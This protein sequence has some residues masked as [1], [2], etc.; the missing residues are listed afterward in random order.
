MARRK[1]LYRRERH[2]IRR[3]TRLSVLGIGGM[4]L[5]SLG[6]P[7][8]AAPRISTTALPS[9][10]VGQPLAPGSTTQRIPQ[11]VAGTFANPYVVNGN[12]GTITQDSPA[13]ILQWGSFD[14]GSSSKVVINLPSENAVLLNKVSGGEYLNKTVIEGMLT[15]NGKGQ[16]YIYN[17]NGIIF[18]KNSVVDLNTFVATTLKVDDS[19]FLGGLLVPS[20]SP[21]FEAE[22]AAPGGITVEGVSALERARITAARGG[23]ILLVAPTIENNGV[24]SAPDGQ[25]ALAAGGRVYL[26]SPSDKNMRG[27]LIEV[28]SRNLTSKTSSVTNQSLGQVLV[29]RGNA[30]L[31]GYA[32]N[33]NGLVSATT[34]VALNGSIYLHARDQASKSNTTDPAKAVRGGTLILGEGS[35]TEI[36]PTLG[37]GIWTHDNKLIPTK[38][39]SSSFMRS[40]ADLSGNTV[41]LMQGA[42]LVVPGGDV[43]VS[44]RVDP[45]AAAPS[46]SS[47]SRI[48]LEEGARIDVS[49]STSALDMEDNVIEV[50]LRGTEL[51]DVP[52]QRYAVYRGA[53]VYVDVRKGTTLGNIQGW[54]DGVQHS[55]GEFT[56]NGGKVLFRSDGDV[57]LA[58]G[59]MVNVSG[60]GINYRD[61]YINT[62]KLI[63][64]NR[65]YDIGSASPDLV[66]DKFYTNSTPTQR[67][68]QK[69]Y[70]QG[71]N[72]GSITVDASAAVLRGDLKGSA[73]AGVLQRDAGASSRPKGGEL[74]IG[75]KIDISGYLGF[76]FRS[77]VNLGGTSTSAI[78][79]PAFGDAWTNANSGLKSTL[80]LDMDQLGGNGFSRVGVYTL[81]DIVVSKPATLSAGGELT[82]YAMNGVQVNANITAPGGALKA[83]SALDKV[84]VASGVT[85][86]TAG[87]WTNDRNGAATDGNGNPTDTIVTG[88][89]NIDL[90][91]LTVEIGD[92]VTLDVSG[93]AWLSSAGKTTAGKGGSIN[94]KAN[95]VDK[96]QSLDLDL[97]GVLSLGRNLTLSGYGVGTGG[98]VSLAGRNV[99]IG[100]AAAHANDLSLD[101][102]WF[103]RGGFSSY[104][105][106][107]A[108]NLTVAAG[109]TLTPRM[110]NWIARSNTASQ[111]SGLMRNA[112]SIGTLPLAGASGSRGAASVSLTAASAAADGY[113][114]LWLK[115]GASIVTDPGGSVTLSAGRQLT[116]DGTVRTPGGAINLY[117]TP[118]V[119]EVDYR[120]ERAVWLGAHSLLDASGTAARLW[121][122]GYGL[123]QGDVLGGG[124][125]KIGR[126]DKVTGTFSALTGYVVAESG[127]RLN[128]SGT[129]APMHLNGGRGRVDV[130]RVAS[131]GGTIDIRAQEG[132]LFEGSFSAAGGNY[133]T[134][135]G[136]LNLSVDR[137]SIATY[138][139]Y[140]TAPRT[141]VLARVKPNAGSP[142]EGI[143]PHGLAA[144]QAIT[145]YDGVGYI[146]AD[147]IN[148]GG[149]DR[150]R[151]KAQDVVSFD[152]HGGSLSLT[153]RTSLVVDAPVTSLANGAAGSTV[154]LNSA[155]VQLGNADW[156]Y[157]AAGAAATATGGNGALAVNATTID[158]V[159]RSVL[160]GF[161]LT[162]FVAREDIRLVGQLDVDTTAV[163]P[164]VLTPLHAI[165]TFSA[166]GAT[167][168]TAGQIYPTSMSEFT[169]HGVGSGNS[170]TFNSNGQ[171]AASPLSAAGTLTVKAEDIYQRGVLRA[172][173]GRLD[174][175][176]DNNL[177]YAPGSLTS[178]AGNGTVPLGRI[179]NGRQWLY[180][181]GNGYT[182][183]LNDSA[184]TNAVSLPEKAVVSKGRNVTF[185]SGAT[186]DLSGGGK[187][188][189]YEFTAGPGGSKD[190][191]AASG[192]TNGIY[193][194]LPG[195]TA[196]VA[197]RDFQYGQ[198]SALQSGE[199]IYLS[200][201]P[202]LAAGYYTLLP[203]H[204]ALLPGAYAVTLASGTR[205]MTA[206][207]TYLKTDGTW[208]V[209][210]YRASVGSS[211]SRSNGYQVYS[212]SQA[213]TYSEFSDYSASSFF[214]GTNWTQPVDGGHAA[215]AVTDSLT[216]KGL[217]NLQAGTGGK[218]GIA[219]I[220]AP[221]IEVVAEES[222]STGSALKLLAADLTALNADSLLLGGLR[223]IKSDGIHLTVGAQTVTASNNAAHPLSGSEIML[224]ATDT[225][226]AK[227]NSVVSSSGVYTGTRGDLIVEGTG[228]GA[229]G[230]L[231]RVS[232]GAQRSLVRTTPAGNTGTL[233]IQAGA[234]VSASA[235]MALDA[236]KQLNF[237]GNL[238]LGPGAAL[239]LGASRISLG[240]SAPSGLPGLQFSGARLAALNSLASLGLT[241]YST[242][243]IYG[244]VTLGRDG[245]T[246]LTVRA[247]G[248]QSYNNTSADTTRLLADTVRFEGGGSFSLATPAPASAQGTLNVAAKS[249][250]VGSGTFEVRGN[251]GVNLNALSEIRMDGKSGMLSVQGD[252]NATAGR[253]AASSG[254]DGVIKASGNLVL[255]KTATPTAPSTTSILGGRIGFVG[256]TILSDGDISAHS[257][258]ITMTASN[259]V[260]IASGSLDAA[261]EAI[262]YGSKTAYSGGGKVVLDGGTGSV[263]VDA[264]TTIDVSSTRADAGTLSVTSS[265][266][267]SG[268]VTLAGT[269][270]GA[271]GADADGVT[272]AQG[273]FISDT[274]V[275]SGF[276]A[277]NQKL[278]NSGFGGTRQFSVRHGDVALAVG[279]TITAK[280]VLISLDNGNLTVGGTIDARG[281]KGGTIQLY[282]AQATATGNSGN[283]TLQNTARLLA[284][285]T[286]AASSAA[287]SSGDG[288]KVTLGSANAAG[289]T[290]AGTSGNSSLSVLSGAVIDVSG[291]GSGQAG[292]VLLRAPR[293]GSGAGT[294]LAISALA[295]TI[296]GSGETVLEGYKVYTGTQITAAAGTSSNLDARTTGTMY[297]E[298]STF[299]GNSG[300]ILSRLGATSSG[301]LLRTGI[302][303][304]STGDLLVNVNETATN[305]KD[306]GWDLNQWRFGG[307]PGMLTLRAASNL[308][309][310]GSISDGFVKPTTTT[311]MPDWSLDPTGGA[312]WSYR[313]VGGARTASANPLAVN[314]STSAGDVKVTF[315][316]T[317]TSG[318]D[319]SVAL[320][321]TGS[322]SID[323][324]AGRDIVL[325]SVGTGTGLIGATI[326]TAGRHVSTQ[327]VDRTLPDYSASDSTTATPKNQTANTAY[328][329]GT[330]TL[331]AEFAQG[332][333]SIGL[334]A[335]RNITGPATYQVVNNWLFRRGKTTTDANGNL[336][337][338]TSSTGATSTR[339]TLSTAWWSR[340][341]YFNQ[342]VATLAGGDV[343]VI[344]GGNITDLALSTATNGQV[345]GAAPG[346]APLTE[347][348]GGNLSLSA[349][350][351]IYGGSF[352]VQKGEGNITAAGS[353]LGGTRTVNGALLRPILA[354]GDASINV[355]AGS[356]LEIETV[357]NPTMTRQSTANAALVTNPVSSFTPSHYSYFVTY[358]E[359]SSVSLTALTGSVL[360]NNNVDTMKAAVG[361]LI[362]F[363]VAQKY[364][365]AYGDFYLYYP[366][367]FHA[368]ALTGNLVLNNGFSLSP[369]AIGQLDLLATGSVKT[370]FSSGID[371]RPIAMLDINPASIPNIYAP[372]ALYATDTTEFDRYK[373]VGKE[374]LLTHTESGLHANDDVA[375]SVVALTGDVIG[376]N[377]FTSLLG[378]SIKGDTL[379][380]PKKAEIIAGRDIVDFGFRIQHMSDSDVSLVEAGRDVVDS[381]N[382]TQQ[383]YVRH[384]VTGPGLLEVQA[385]RNID[386]GNSRG[387]FSRGNLDN[388]YLAEGGASLNLVAGATPDYAGFAQQ[389]MT[390][391]DFSLS[392]Q[393]AMIAYMYQVQP[394]LPAGLDAA[395]AWTAFN[396]LS[397]AQR[398]V[399][400]EPRKALI[401]TRFFALVR[402]ASKKPDG[403]LNTDLTKFDGLIANLFPTA[404]IGDGDINVFGSQLKTEQGGGID[405][406]APGGSVYA[407]LSSP[408]AYL[409][410]KSEADL[411]IFTVRGGTIQ[412]L[413]KND[414]LVNQGR[415][416]TL[417]GG[418]ITIVSQ[419]H[420]IDAGKGAK[421]ASSAPPPLLTTDPY[422]N[423]VI[424]ISASISGSGV[425][426]KKTRPDIP[427][428][429]AYLIA[430]RGTIAAGDAGISCS[431][432]CDLNAP[433]ISNPDNIFGAKGVVGV[434]KADSIGMSGVTA[435]TNTGVTKTDSFTAGP[436]S[437]PTSGRTLTVE[438]VSSA[439][440]AG[441]LPV[442]QG[443]QNGG[444]QRISGGATAGDASA[445]S[446]GGQA[447]T[448]RKKED[449]Q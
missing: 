224:A 64:A 363:T 332:G 81:G 111:S 166:A 315:G 320:V 399:F 252:L 14:I 76:D 349:G 187:L 443:N 9:G 54:L 300:S 165:G 404:D 152:T 286:M 16:V 414:F 201:I 11:V 393:T 18:G 331:S 395:A 109:T 275:I 210:G 250:Q 269:L 253:F 215:F 203:A 85:L 57:I 77:H 239:N 440:D 80:D 211:D 89:G 125:I 420:D 96:S 405:V 343:K 47:T 112:Y 367:S 412:A 61:G 391:S 376:Y 21:Q 314:S 137:E 357:L 361:N 370:N 263:L 36:L 430:P 142:G 116:V 56:S 93:G 6:N 356:D 424:D 362:N 421:T 32:V 147:T 90:S 437:D 129:S 65:I 258:S 384:I 136:T 365:K 131:A 288:G 212:S 241:S 422:G 183:A 151:L 359:D 426:T 327:S 264:G 364:D 407:G 446:S 279:E 167:S 351:N 63:S 282:A 382:Q 87:R 132:I 13:G 193:A 49:G 309:I 196:S 355:T 25:V 82:L 278:N 180:D 304:R 83:A 62:T 199:R 448:G 298:S 162:R 177:V 114:R 123:T 12:T 401:S 389:N 410:D 243:D 254:K 100:G 311:A 108:G 168:F 26:T 388:P 425:A 156:R 257:G 238:G 247:A 190:I 344:A 39:D 41:H 153:P 293:V 176:A 323:V 235:S 105:V 274:D 303:V 308:T 217:L 369:S 397:V 403:T 122:N 55:V 74:I 86:D 221:A 139:G 411:G 208:V 301:V 441:Q 324:A 322:G 338:A 79:T 438:V 285:A 170:I 249:I 84:S 219:D 188:Y 200:G 225:V 402:A 35:V 415:V 178:V 244:P 409:R 1:N 40:V 265:N 191:L 92:D 228:S 321:R 126:L 232:S 73:T 289:A 431:G 287:G 439:G 442:T 164:D 46:A 113:G 316:R 19:R 120:A 160:Q 141:L 23:K 195:Y 121:S 310:K 326:Y 273:N 99:V 207:A 94:L 223:E 335:A 43:T 44:A 312:S 159:G 360:V 28:D 368:A 38:G 15:G 284:S 5:A 220:S 307:Q 328:T 294:D 124:T 22:N 171:S 342:G 434:P 209:S 290:V 381:T 291:L 392:D 202:G 306:R 352:Y 33:Q 58:K 267:S 184:A 255:A 133:T 305:A 59:S 169:L 345:P 75:A 214:A 70:W 128:V 266:G 268:A 261:G 339:E 379:V 417:G 134:A 48:Y 276:G 7:A 117:L 157:Q 30:T 143:V 385:G 449:S 8:Y 271:S 95:V 145:G 42:S 358:G 161:S 104:S 413:V 68:F 371:T 102:L 297:T 78:A 280:D 154:S 29:E 283:V 97:G 240:D 182:V 198:D 295:G 150:V 260:H 262:V 428:S 337:F 292:S 91:G 149:F 67:D 340:Y 66:Y 140:S 296:I 256:N 181:F 213:R 146:L 186:I 138:T 270:K 27:F 233:D 408:P 127:A 53:K 222:Q 106:T 334:N 37:D 69:G 230:A 237:N 383:S 432:I 103:T 192:N 325:D 435:P 347:R 20:S 406:F 185:S 34:S 24:L 189:G 229:D 10:P 390:L 277:L 234:F 318:T 52:S 423:T 341:D 216:L 110:D 272:G 350:G 299:V 333:G 226:T 445:S 71:S 372:R 353:I 400:L 354:L 380:T 281:E 248:I 387:I 433:K 386:L 31:V 377:Y 429:N 416:F 158:L 72:A 329:S 378:T 107:A 3:P 227:T 302:E 204:Y 118:G 375:V 155:N 246:T 173:F 194:I 419:Y 4:V 319:Q 374:A 144:D 236:T 396:K 88:G 336:I 346:V 447:S 130:T 115:D 60:G 163:L 179:T 172:P 251:T 259:G 2:S 366:G 245:M 17:S 205:D 119:S 135:G 231:L 330:V 51:A 98:A 348:G 206:K 45:S 373:G 436:P 101:P 50:E 313:L 218:R 197:P 418:D 175:E 174:L 394:T 242:L 317:S 398:M 444:A 148:G 427:D